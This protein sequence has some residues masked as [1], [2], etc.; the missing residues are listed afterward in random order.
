MLKLLIIFTVYAV[1]V[2]VEDIDGVAGD[3]VDLVG[4]VASSRKLKKLSTA[5]PISLLSLSILKN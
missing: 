5:L 4:V 1:D 2:V 3:I